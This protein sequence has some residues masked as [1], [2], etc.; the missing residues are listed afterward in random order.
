MSF[1]PPD[2]QM[3]AQ[4]PPPAPMGAVQG[5]KPQKKSMQTTFLGTGATPTNETGPKGGATLLGQ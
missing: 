2:V 3:P 5:Q 4:P 1:K